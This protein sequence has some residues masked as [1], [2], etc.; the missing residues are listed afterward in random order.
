MSKRAI[1]REVSDESIRQY[2]DGIGLYDL[3]SAEDEVRLAKAIETGRKAEIALETEKDS[4]KRRKLGE[5]VRRGEDARQTF[6]RSNLRLV[7]SIAKRYG[8]A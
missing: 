5:M 8:H 1:E 3:L 6:I 7:V 4:T 2:L